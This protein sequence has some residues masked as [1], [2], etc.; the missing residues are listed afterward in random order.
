MLATAGCARSR[1]PHLARLYRDLGPEDGQPPLIVI[2]G[3]FGSQLRDKRTRR[4]IWPESDVSL[5]LSNYEQIELAID[6]E[7]LEPITGNVEAFDI[8]RK[9]LGR[10]F[11]GALLQT[12]EAIG[13]YRRMHPGQIPN[14][15]GRQFYVYP[16]D[17]RLDNVASVQGLHRL[18][19][20]VALD[21]GNPDLRVDV[22]GHSNGG[23][24]ARYYARYGTADM[25]TH[26]ATEP[27]W[28]GS[29]RIR[30]LLLMGT[31]NL[32]TMQP[33]L[34]YVRGEEV[35]L[36][37]IP[38]EVVATCPGTLQLMPHPEITWLCNMRGEPLD[39]DVYEL[40]S[41]RELKWS[42]FSDQARS[43]AAHRHGGGQQG[44][45]Y[46][47]TLEAYL[48]KHM[49]RGRKF[50]QVLSRPAQREEP[51]PYIFGGDCTPTVA[52]LVVES[53]G[54]IL[55]AH[56]RPATIRKPISGVDYENLIN[57]PGDGVVT[58]LSL[59]G[60]QPAGDGN[61]LAE[62]RIAHSIFLCEEHLRLTGN[63]SFQDN[64]LYTLLSARTD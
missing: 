31:P 32:G 54:S 25:L 39:L 41:W 40:D 44:R 17:W 34:S 59:M 1:A 64:L 36:G 14:E 9:G 13:G 26:G 52:R 27:T 5:L 57:E 18:I 8:F 50:Q 45:R 38:P 37:E 56:E 35:G 11:Y 62:L 30:R 51:L 63:L 2:P 12:L 60:R 10:D 49:A 23:L 22:L 16:Y 55:R 7:T 19:E 29:S 46:L 61:T 28:N 47:A 42:I 21:H 3:A 43:R 33:V 4:E 20:Q 48:A 6:P 15:S 53:R 58:R 24:L